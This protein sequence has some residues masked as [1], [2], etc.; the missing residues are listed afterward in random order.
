MPPLRGP[1]GGLLGE[2][3]ATAAPDLPM[4]AGAEPGPEPQPDAGEASRWINAR[5]E[6]HPAGTALRLAQTYT[7]AFAIEAVADSNLG[8]SGSAPSAAPATDAEY[9]LTVQL[10]SDDF[11]IGDRQRPLRVLPGGLSAGKARF[12]ITP[13]HDGAGRITAT[14]HKD[15]NF[16]QR[17]VLTLQVGDAAHAQPDVQRTGRPLAALATLR[18]RDIGISVEPAP[19]GGFECTVWGMAQAR[20]KL[21]IQDTELADAIEQLRRALMK[22]VTRQDDAGTYPFQDAIAIAPAERD[23]ALR[24]LAK[25][26]F[27]LYRLL[28]HHPAADRQCKEIG[29]WLCRQARDPALVLDLQ[30][31]GT[32]FPVPWALLYLAERWDDAT[33]DWDGFL[34]MRHVVEQIPLQNDMGLVD[35]RIEEAD[36]GLSVSLNLNLDIDRQMSLDVV[37]RQAAYWDTLAASRPT[38]RVTRR[39]TGAA[40]LGALGDPRTDDEILYLYCHATAVGLD[41]AGGPNASSL[42]LDADTSLTLQDLNLYADT[43]RK[44]AGHPLVFINACESADLSPLFYNGFVP[45]FMSK[46][47]RGVIGT[48]C[49]MPALF[50]AEWAR[51][52]FDALLAGKPLGDTVLALRRSFLSDHGNPLGLLY[53]LHCNAD[54]QVVP[55]VTP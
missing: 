29:D 39:T 32:S 54:T 2:E 13:L 46:G 20:A 24:V 55:A 51:A 15:G 36:D 34:G 25:A 19:G 50:A 44:L 43:D 3:A 4:S 18:R 21:P 48:E 28:F 41:G 22:V 33:L 40:L 35:G 52:F 53:G 10:D 27:T 14:F 42:R 45:Y 31:I 12:D 8:A 17:M 37:Q 30:V 49:K 23:A 26:G 7:L 6:D 1:G 47:A 9:A 38:L 16:V 11:S 5:I